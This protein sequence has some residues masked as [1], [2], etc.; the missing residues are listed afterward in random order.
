[1]A[2]SGD[3][4]A[5]DA[6]RMRSRRALIALPLIVLMLAACAAVAGLVFWKLHA[7]SVAAPDRES[8]AARRQ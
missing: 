2:D 7:G 6:R 1:M 5:L 8:G 3:R 4:A